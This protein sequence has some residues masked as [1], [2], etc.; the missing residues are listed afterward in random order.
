LREHRMLEPGDRVLLA[1]SG[2]A[3]SSAM[4]RVLAR[5]RRTLPFAF[6]LVGCHVV[7]DLFPRNEAGEAWLDRFFAELGVP[8]RRVFIEASRRLGQ[9][10]PTCFTCAR[11]RRRALVATAEAEGCTK[12]AFG[13][14]L[15]DIVETLLLNMI[16]CGAIAGMPVRLE[17]DRHPITIIRPM[18][19]VK[20]AEAKAFAAGAGIVP[21]QQRCGMGIDRRRASV[22]RAIAELAEGDDRVRDN[23]FAALG[24]V[25]ADYLLEKARGGGLGEPR[26]EDGGTGLIE[27]RWNSSRPARGE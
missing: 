18:C 13:H 27:D 22:K 4:A 11:E 23:L 2:G 25:R 17:L 21:A 3:D 10:A 15:D 14:H 12:L 7:T 8:L 19:R 24:R 1:I 6:E 5:K 16:H 20:E 26:D 9:Q